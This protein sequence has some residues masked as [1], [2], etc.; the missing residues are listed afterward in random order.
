MFFLIFLLSFIGGVFFGPIL[1]ISLKIILI[2]LIILLSF[3]SIFYRRGSKILNL[4]ISLVSF[5]LIF[6]IFGV[7]R[8]NQVSTESMFLKNFIDQDFDI[9]LFGYIDNQPEI[10]LSE[11]KF[12]FLAKKIKVANYTNFLNEKILIVTNLYP[13]FEYGQAIQLT[14]RLK[15]PKKFEDFDYRSYLEKENIFSIIYYP[16]IEP[17]QELKNCHQFRGFFGLV[18]KLKIFLFKNIFKIK[19]SFEESV[20]KSISE[21][22]ASLINGIL[23]GSRENLPNELVKAF[24]KTGITHI[25]AIS[26]YNITIIANYIMAFLLFFMTRKRAFWFAV[27]GILFFTVL[28]GASASV[29]RA[30]IMGILTLVAYQSG[31]FYDAT[32]SVV[33]AGALMVLINP[34]ILKYDVGFQLSFLATLGLIYI[35]PIIKEKLK[36]LPEFFNLK[37]GLVATISAQLMILPV[38]LLN[39]KN[40]SLVSIPVNVLILPF[41]PLTMLSG[42]IS[43][44]SGII[45][46]EIGQIFGL[47]AWFLSSYIIL[48][49]KSFSSL[50]ISA[51]KISINWQFVFIFYLLII[52]LVYLNTRKKENK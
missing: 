29:F 3:I 43:G 21:P 12:V 36:N 46:S 51:K 35:A 40:L 44:I 7:L 52:F 38:I 20:F 37:E 27:A 30:A 42:F 16:K 1:N 26:G 13:K 9:T 14:G 18:A 31:R 47:I 45:W 17:C 2:F 10:L 48:I 34:K 41:I 6:F 23:L 49:V 11:Q 33:F 8:F 24:Q 4:Q 5:A 25:L 19:D 15:S 39:F 32:N 28:T 50:T 22:S